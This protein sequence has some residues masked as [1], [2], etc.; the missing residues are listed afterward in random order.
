MQIEHLGRK[1]HYCTEVS[2]ND[3]K[4]IDKGIGFIRGHTER[5]QTN[6]RDYVHG[7]K[8]ISSGLQSGNTAQNNVF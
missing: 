2:G 7:C 5:A 4:T 1:T 8:L 3:S 6:K